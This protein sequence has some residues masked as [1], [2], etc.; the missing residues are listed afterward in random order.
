MLDE[1]DHNRHASVCRLFYFV[2]IMGAVSQICYFIYSDLHNPSEVILMTPAL[3]VSVSAVRKPNRSPRNVYWCGYRNM[4][5]QFDFNMGDHLFP[6][7]N[8]TELLPG[9]VSGK[10]D[11]K[12]MLR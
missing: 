11:G 6:E 3:P 4:F 8:V 10:D 9:F 7:N 12:Y 5:D 1:M 2:V